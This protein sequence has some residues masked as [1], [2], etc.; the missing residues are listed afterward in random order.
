MFRFCGQKTWR[1]R[2]CFFPRLQRLWGKVRR[3][4]TRLRFCACVCVWRSACAHQFHFFSGQDQSTVAQR[5]EM[6]VAECSL[7]SCVWTRFPNM[8]PHY[9]WGLHVNIEE[10]KL[11]HSNWTNK[12]VCA[13]IQQAVGPHKDLL[14]IT[15]RRNLI[16]NG[17]VSHSSGLAKTILQGLVKGGRRQLRQTEEEVGRQR[18]GMDRPGVRQIPETGKNG[19]NWLWNHLWFPNDRRS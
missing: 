4:I 8:F 13:K 19:G 11:I 18:Q 14:T 1:L 10:K 2:S 17:Y 9:A 7:T 15:K 6:T 5:A 12:E 16:C 3:F